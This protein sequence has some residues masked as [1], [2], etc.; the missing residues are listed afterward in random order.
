[1]SITPT[2][3]A[4]K[5][6]AG[7]TA[8]KPAPRRKIPAELLPS[9]L[10]GEGPGE[11]GGF[12]VPYD[13]NLLDRARTQGQFGDWQSLA[14]LNRDSLQHHPDRAKLTLLAAAGR[15]QT[16]QDAEARQFI[17][18]AQDWGVSKKLISQILIAGV[19]NSIG[20][21][22]AI[23][24]QQHRAL[25]HFESAITIG[26][27]G[28][29][30]KLLTQA[31][32]G[33]QLHQLG[34]P[35]PEGFLKVGAG[36]TA[37]AA[38]KLPPTAKNL[39]T[40]TETLQQHKTELD[41]QLKK[42]ANELA[43]LRKNLSANLK[44]EVANAARQIGDFIS[45]QNYFSTGQLSDIQLEMNGWP[46][47]TDFM[48]YLVKLIDL[49]DYD[50]IIEFG[51][52]AST[53]AI[54]KTLTKL[55]PRRQGK[56]PVGFASFDHLEQYYQQT[57]AQLKHAGLADALQLHLAPLAEYTAPNGNHYPYYSC[58][59]ALAALAQQHANQPLRLL[60]SIDGP[61]AKTGKHARYPAAPLILAHF[62]GASIDLLLDDAVRA[63]EKEIAALWQT[64]ITAAGMHATH[65][66][67]ELE[68]GASL[69]HIE[70]QT[71]GH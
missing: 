3:K 20:R 44:T 37:I 55:A 54:A 46:V 36:G 49:N 61:P 45:L 29:D 15:L 6:G 69:I 25:Q 22:A 42:Q 57:Q 33:E 62:K 43:S 8:S 51:S 70:G 60:V 53:L 47:S 56:P 52:G 14:Q 35:T 31:R 71:S 5:V 13:E 41:A 48:L 2:E 16:G 27:P 59:L 4:K 12:V 21:A 11:R 63:E 30:A 68:K 58:Q 9:L 1:M 34:L 26:T 32:T 50:L 66:Y 38:P 40:L 39:E 19:H 64:D 67:I 28:S 24:N 7:K 10:A 17:R 23:G 65:Q 18:L